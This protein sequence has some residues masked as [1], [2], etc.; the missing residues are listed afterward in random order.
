MASLDLAPG[1]L[2]AL[3]RLGARVVLDD[4]GVAY[5]SFAYLKQF[6]VRG[7]KLDRGFVVGVPSDGTDAAIVRAIIS[8]ARSLK[9]RVVAEGIEYPEQRAYLIDQGCAEGQGYLFSK[10]LPSSAIDA[11]FAAPPHAQ[12]QR[13]LLLPNR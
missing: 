3:H 6:Q 4:L 8:L 1:V 10:P 9:L 11:L 2:R 5:S 12:G 7:V 13:V